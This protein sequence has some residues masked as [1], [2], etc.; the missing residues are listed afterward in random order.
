MSTPTGTSAVPTETPPP[1]FGCPKCKS[2]IPAGAEVCPICRSDIR[3]KTPEEISSEKFWG[4][5][6]FAKDWIG[7]PAAAL[8]AMLAF[9][10]P[11]KDGFLAL[12]HADG[13][14]LTFVGERLDY[15]NVGTEKLFWS[16]KYDKVVLNAQFLQGAIDNKGLSQITVR[17]EMECSRSISGKVLN[18]K[19]GFTEITTVN[20]LKD[21]FII[22]PGET[23]YVNVVL[24]EAGSP[25]EGYTTLLKP[26]N[27]G[28]PYFDKYGSKIGMFA[29]DEKKPM[30]TFLDRASDSRI[31]EREQFCQGMIMGMP[32]GRDPIDCVNDTHL[33]AIEPVYLW[34][35][36]VHRVI[37]QSD[38]FRKATNGIGRAPGIILRT[39]AEPNCTE[40]VNT[41]KQVMSKFTPAVTV[42]I[43]PGNATGLSDCGAP[44]LPDP[45][46]T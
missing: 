37:A 21:D 14:S 30:P 40:A 27:C 45:K 2:E 13:G 39:C 33:I 25:N 42:W 4:G 23:K 22:A 12:I 8:T 15:I 24:I 38:E 6:R 17:P 34:E 5:L 18:S 11:A 29:I 19:Y 36:A 43:C 41:V 35:R 10:G 3:V 28:V 26:G 31:A 7:F 46:G 32:L 44:V 9:I 20:A 1:H 16:E